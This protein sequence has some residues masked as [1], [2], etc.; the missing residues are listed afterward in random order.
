[1][2][3]QLLALLLS[4]AFGS[5]H[6]AEPAA[7]TAKAEPG[8]KADEALRVLKTGNERFASGKSE[9]PH[10]GQDLRAALEQAQHPFAVVLGCSDSRVPPEL[11]FDQGFGDLFIVRVA[12]NVAETDVVASIEYA[13]DHLQTQL[14]VVMGHTN[15]GAV[16]AAVD[17]LNSADGEAAEVVSLLYDIEPAVADVPKGLSREETIAKVVR[18]NVELSVRRLTRVPDI[19]RNIKAGTIKIVG[20]VYDMHSGKVEFLE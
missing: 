19:R 11:V 8:I 7:H 15:C 20:A 2:K 12:G 13:V 1:M 5:L 17:H 18:K 9:H 10:E 4:L 3:P 14:V 6:A 16:S